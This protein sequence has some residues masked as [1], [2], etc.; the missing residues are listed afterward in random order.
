M[1]MPESA[2]LGRMMRYIGWP[3]AMLLAWDVLVTGLYILL[4]HPDRLI[5]TLPMTLLGSALALF[6][7]FRNSAAYARWWEARTLW[8]AMVNSSRSFAREALNLIDN[9]PETLALR[10][11]LVRRQIAYVHALRCHLRRQECWEEIEPF[12]P[13]GEVQELRRMTNVPNAILTG[14]D[15]LI[16]TAAEQGWIDSMRRIQI[17]QELVAISNAQGGME[18]IKNTPLP[19]EY[20][21]YP[22][23][24]VRVF[25]IIL[26]IGLV[27]SLLLFTPL[28][29]TV[30]GFMFLAM[31]RIGAD[32]QNPFAN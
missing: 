13:E 20:D 2:S 22:T 30:V 14:T 27:D 32:L 6:I 7:G 8:G 5:P 26:P 15:R 3:L 31:D 1:V 29:S 4:P 28:A 9:R 21:F 12:L 10:Q 24:F 19:R 25:C 11:T 16:T 18:R 17:E 23:L